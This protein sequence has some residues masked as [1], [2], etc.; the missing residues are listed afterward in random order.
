LHKK[1]IAWTLK[2]LHIT[3]WYPSP[4]NPWEAIWIKR[5][6][7]ALAKH[8]ESYYVLH[9]EVKTSPRFL[10]RRY[11]SPST[12]Q[13][14]LE[15]PL[16]RWRIIEIASAALLTY[17]LIKLRANR[18]DVITI[19]VAYPNLTY[20]HVLKR[21]FAVPIVI[22][23]HWSAYH[24]HFG[25]KNPSKLK[26]I[27]RI[28]RQGTPVVA[29]SAAL[30][31]DIAA[32]SDARFQGHV[33]PNVVER[34][35]FFFKEGE[36]KERFFMASKWKTPKKPLVIL[37]AFKLFLADYPHFDLVVGGYGDETDKIRR[38]IDDNN[39][40]DR[41]TLVGALSV[42]EMASQYRSCLAF[43]HC[44]DYETFSVVCAEA[45][46]CGTPVIASRVGGITEFVDATDGVLVDENS[47]I[48]WLDALKLFTSRCHSFDPRLISQ[49][50]NDRFSAERVGRLYFEALRD[51]V[52]SN[53]K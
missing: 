39:L 9:L 48:A 40:G 21:W 46:C 8:V 36:R 24:F 2:V 35:F 42:E 7:D 17:Y 28:F 4:E 14:V 19:H 32:F 49:K 44:S 37:E 31:S 29:V 30:L 50:A 25:V 11:E 52:E 16:Q 10:F 23:E 27:R 38:Y 18:Y 51:V 33:V 1:N 41:I 15:F 22:S 47:V 45:L 43:L 13:R 20:W 34:T 12:M 26:R 3:N 5:H 53:K 6:I